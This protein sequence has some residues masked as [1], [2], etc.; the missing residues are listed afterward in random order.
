MLRSLGS[1]LSRRSAL[2]KQSFFARHSQ[3]LLLHSSSISLGEEEDVATTTT[4]TPPSQSPEVDVS[5]QHKHEFKAETNKLLN[6]VAQSL[7]S[8][9]EVFVRELVSN[10]ADALEKARYLQTTQADVVDNDIELAIRITTD[11][12]NNT[13]TIEDSGIGMSEDELVENLGTIARSGSK[14]FVEQLSKEGGATVSAQENIIG[15]F[16]VGFYAGFMVGDDITVYSKSYAQDKTANMWNSDGI[17]SYSIAPATNVTRGT[18]IVIKLRDDAKDFSKDS[19]IKRIVKKYSNFVGFPVYING[20]QVNTVQP[21]WMKPARDISEEEHT[22]FY[23]LLSDNSI[24]SPMFSIPYSVD[25][26]I[27]LRSLIYIPTMNMEKFG[28]S[29]MKN[30]VSLY[31]RKVLI[32][33]HVEGLLPEWMRFATGVVDSEDIPL[34]LS[35]EMLQNSS[36]IRKMGAIVTNRVLSHIEK[37]AVEDRDSFIQFS[38]EFGNFLREGVLQ[39]QGYEKKLMKLLTFQSTEFEGLEKTTLGEY[40]QRMEEKEKD[41]TNGDSDEDAEKKE[42]DPILYIVAKNRDAAI[43]SPYLEKFK[44]SGQEVLILTNTLDEF[45]MDRANAFEGRPLLSVQSSK[46]AN[47]DASDS[48]SEDDSK[49]LLGAFKSTLGEK[50]LEAKMSSRLTTSPVIIVDHESAPKRM[51]MQ[52]L[53]D[54]QG[55]GALPIPPLSLEI[56]PSHPII[57]NL[58]PALSNGDDTKKS[59]EAVI[60]QLFDNA[61]ILAGLMTE[62]NSEMS[63]MVDRINNLCLSVL[64]KEEPKE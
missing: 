9:R 43:R 52:M 56:N 25:A 51:M 15:Q 17:G 41:T 34:N 19:E 16:G 48:L 21:L 35:R 1:L 27:H 28:M 13:F 64:S 40:V 10:S 20:S 7:Y 49:V 62:A 44:S 54:Q 29:R 37:Q 36:L 14:A 38:E 3:G 18:K 60:E 47:E 23:R 12:E 45:V 8:E 33:Q 42:K 4:S 26:P 53:S 39:D 22:E 59:A 2:K 11:E 6:I 5:K 24:D 63:T 58:I 61:L 46:V 32:K 57:T 30:N 31:C 55:L 50:L